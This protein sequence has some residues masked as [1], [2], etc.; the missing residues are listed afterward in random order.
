MALGVVPEVVPLDEHLWTSE[1]PF[2]VPPFLK[3]N[4]S[5]AYPTSYPPTYQ[6]PDWPISPTNHR[7]PQHHHLQ[8]SDQQIQLYLLELVEKL[9]LPKL[10]YV[11]AQSPL[12]IT[13]L[14]NSP[15]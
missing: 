11:L 3:A 1:S 14:R 12:I 6:L 4:P 2:L 7:T 5:S 9:I 15:A 8:V 10:I 13:P